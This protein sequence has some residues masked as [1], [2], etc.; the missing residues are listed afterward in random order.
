MLG[1]AALGQ[2]NLDAVEVARNH[3]PLEDGAGLVQQLRDRVARGDVGEREQLD[4]GR[5]RQLRGRA[6]G[7]VAG[8]G[9]PLGVRVHE[10]GLVHKQI[11]AMG[12]GSGQVAWSG[13]ARD[14]DRPTAPRF[15]QHLLG[16][17][18]V[19][20]LPALESTEVRARLHPQLAR[21]RLVEPPRTLP[22]DQGVAESAHTVVHRERGHSVT[23]AF[24]FGLRLELG[25]LDLERK[26][27]DDRGEHLEQPP[28]PGRAEHSERARACLEPVRLE[29]SR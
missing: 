20:R 21:A 15:P 5:R 14:N 12:D 10:G 7:A 29:H 13:V 22:F 9:G 16:T 27:P 3:G 11:R 28:Q 1:R 8:G 26:P 17:N 24:E 19:D 2:R 25:G 18:T 4:L 23:V 6:G